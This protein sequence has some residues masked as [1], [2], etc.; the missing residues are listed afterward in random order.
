MLSRRFSGI[1]E[2]K[3]SS[4]IFPIQ[5]P[6]N[7]FQYMDLYGLHRVAALTPVISTRIFLT[8]GYKVYAINNQT[9]FSRYR[10]W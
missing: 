4:G 3:R 1:I 9:L 6:G 8:A 7:T 10:G 5:S 2:V